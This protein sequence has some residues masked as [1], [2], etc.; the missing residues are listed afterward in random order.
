MHCSTDARIT[1]WQ[2][3]LIATGVATIVMIDVGAGNRPRQFPLRYNVPHRFPQEIV[4]RPVLG[5]V[6][7]SVR[8]TQV[9]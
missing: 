9:Q 1:A 8:Y 2:I 3:A 5:V 4:A 7:L 6:A